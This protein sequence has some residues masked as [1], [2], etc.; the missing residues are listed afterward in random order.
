[1]KLL[2]TW[3]MKQGRKSFATLEAQIG[4]LAAKADKA[5][6]KAAKP[7]KRKA[8][9][10][11]ASTVAWKGCLRH[12]DLPVLTARAITTAT[13][14]YVKHAMKNR[15]AASDS[16]LDPL[17]PPVAG[18]IACRPGLANAT[19]FATTSKEVVSPLTPWVICVGFR[20]DSG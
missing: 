9:I 10:L 3:L 7:L 16:L 14:T 19:V 5:A 6:D 1:M 17:D 8:A 13:A 11:L 4:K 15:A 2:T 20:I 18:H 12:P